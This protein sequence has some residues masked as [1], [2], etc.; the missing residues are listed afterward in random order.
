MFAY[1]KNGRFDFND[2]KDNEKI[3]RVFS[4]MPPRQIEIGMMLGVVALFLASFG[5]MTLADWMRD[6]GLVAANIMKGSALF[7]VVL[8]SAHHALC[9]ATEW[10][11]LKFGM[12][13]E[14]L[15]GITEFFKKTSFVA[16]AYV[17]L[18]VYVITLFVMIVTG[19]TDLPRWASVFNTLPAFLI[20][21]PTK[22]PA[23]GNIA[24]AFMFLGLAILL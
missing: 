7:F 9:G 4:V 16:I 1:T 8:I 11:Y 24:N 18:L 17:G 10:F 12:S 20:L 5:Y 23:K 15:Q 2:M 3:K 21:A 14:T 6:Y 22:L 13:D 19:K